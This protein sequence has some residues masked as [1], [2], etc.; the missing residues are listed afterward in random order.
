MLATVVVAVISAT[1]GILMGLAALIQAR[2]AHSKTDTV[3]EQVEEKIGP[4]EPP[5]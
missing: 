1:P 3:K 5:K 4:L 2:S